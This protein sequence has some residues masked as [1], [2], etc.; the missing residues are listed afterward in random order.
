MR[1]RIY[2]AG[3]LGGLALLV[4]VVAVVFA[5]GRSDPSPPSLRDNPNPSIPGD[6]LYLD[7]DYCFVRA[8]ASGASQAKLACVPQYYGSRLYWLDEDVAGIV[9]YGVSGALL[10]EVNLRTGVQSTTGRPIS[11]ASAK[12]PP[13]G[14]YGGAF[15]PDGTYAF[16]DEG[17][18]FFLLKDGAR[19]KVADFDVP[20]YNQPQVAVWSP[21][22]QWVVVQYYPP[23]SDGP[24]LWIVSRDG[25]TRGT[26]STDVASGPSGSA[27][28]R[29]DGVGVQPPVP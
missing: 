23:R 3:I 15:A 12:D 27:A 17:G 8:A 4:I 9:Q 6:I 14:I 1:T 24:E 22:S 2:A 29:I 18:E 7:E 13:F 5:F 11:E 10:Y 25:Q 28:W 19:T 21:D 20:K 16:F 26:L